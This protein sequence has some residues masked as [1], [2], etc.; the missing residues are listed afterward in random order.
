MDERLLAMWRRIVGREPTEK[1]RVMMAKLRT[2]LPH[3]LLGSPAAVA[4]IILRA[5]MLSL[6]QEKIDGITFSAQQVIHRDLPDR[7]DKAALAALNKMRDHLPIDTKDSLRRLIQTATVWTVLV[8]IVAGAGG[9]MLHGYAT[10]HQQAGQQASMDQ[11]FE[12]C[13]T[14]AEG[15]AMTSKPGVDALRYDSAVYRTQARACA[16]EYADRRADR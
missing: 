16:A 12:R 9:W 11:A 14:A 8:C 1:D 15:F 13:V 4:D 6:L 5:N 7:I 3:E 10:A 2:E